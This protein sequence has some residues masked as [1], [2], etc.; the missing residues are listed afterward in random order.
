MSSPPHRT[1]R[2][3]PGPRGAPPHRPAP[4]PVAV[5]RE[6]IESLREDFDEAALHVA[7]LREY[8]G[9]RLGPVV[10]VPYGVVPPGTVGWRRRVD[11]SPVRSSAPPP[12]EPDAWLYLLVVPRASVGSGVPFLPGAI[13]GG[14]TLRVACSTTPPSMLVAHALSEVGTPLLER[15]ARATCAELESGD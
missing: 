5:E 14:S 12:E 9:F 7:E 1:K 10:D 3:T 11:W 8:T 15:L 4:A 6:A 13:E 2:A